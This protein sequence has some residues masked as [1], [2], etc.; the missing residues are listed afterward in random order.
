M[1]ELSLQWLEEGSLASLHAV[2]PVGHSSTALAPMFAWKHVCA[3][4]LPGSPSL[5]CASEACSSLISRCP[6]R[7]FTR[8]FD[9]EVQGG[10]K[11]G[12]T[13]I[14]DV[15]ERALTAGGLHVT[16]A[17]RL[18]PWLL[19]C[20]CKR[21]GLVQ[22][23]WHSCRRS[24]QDVC[25][26]CI[27]KPSPAAASCL[28]VLYTAP[29]FLPAEGSKLWDIYRGYE[30]SLLE[31]EP[32]DEQAER[33]RSLW[34]RQ[35]AVP[36][37]DGSQTLAAYEDWE[38]SRPGE[39]HWLEVLDRGW[40]FKMGQ[41]CPQKKTRC[42]WM[43]LWVGA[44]VGLRSRTVSASS[45]VCPAPRTPRRKRGLAAARAPQAVV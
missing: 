8:D 32:S 38:R 9:P 12:H 44:L 35:L 20:A 11:E 33:V 10:G 31:S 25:W 26:S 18:P 34:A 5:N 4:P 2:R 7:R 27:D 36:L 16:G 19:C 37:A 24:A 28:L 42:C 39:A 17:Q 15:C 21:V 30:L 23:A 13:R 40:R 41:S 22:P 3:R 45:L 6:P 43:V 29:S 1:S 14:R